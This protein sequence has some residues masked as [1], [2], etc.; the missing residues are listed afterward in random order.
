MSTIT[1]QE[2]LKWLEAMKGH[3]ELVRQ[4]WEIEFSGPKAS[5]M[6]QEVESEIAAL[7]FA[8]ETIRRYEL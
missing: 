6:A 2:A 1:A 8:V 7:A 4:Y 3:K 5:A